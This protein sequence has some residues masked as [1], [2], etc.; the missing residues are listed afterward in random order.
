VHVECARQAGYVLGFDITPVKGSRKDQVPIVNIKGDVG[1]MVAAIW[2]KEHIPQ[3]TVVHHIQDIVDDETGQT[4]LQ[5]YSQKFK[6]ADL[7]LTGTV[8]KATLI[9]QS[10][11][12]VQPAPV[13][14]YGTRRISTIHTNG[15]SHAGRNSLS[16]AKVEEN[17]SEK[18]DNELKRI[19]ATCEVDV[20][21]KWWS[22]PAVEVLPEPAA[23]RVNGTG[24]DAIDHVV[25]AESLGDDSGGHAA[26]AAAALHQDTKPSHQEPIEF[27][28]HKCHFKKVKREPTPVPEP[29][30]PPPAPV[31]VVPREEIRL[32]NHIPPPIGIPPP[33]VEMNQAPRVPPGYAWQVPPS[34]YGNGS[35]NGWSRPSPVSQVSAHISHINGNG[36][37]RL[38]SVVHSPNGHSRPSIQT[39]PHSPLQNG[40]IPHMTNGYPPRS[41]HGGMGMHIPNGN[42]GPYTSPRVETHHLTNGV[43]PPRPNDPPFSN[44]N[45]SHDQMYQRPPYAPAQSSPPLLNNHLQSRANSISHPTSNGH[46]ENGRVNGGA[47]ASPSLRNLLS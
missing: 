47:S 39:V 19:C 3:K 27:Q 34:G 26:L 5:L 13:A 45:G 28:C 17:A 42:Y 40:H 33:D 15:T 36:P 46:Q 38:P 16:H 14:V 43:P 2:C 11:K 41:P 12:A 1:T 18:A 29:P 8:R 30:T 22:F 10:T 32:H 37:P 21:P 7:T 24:H 20:S 6:Q 44:H 9:N 23:I 4:A 31:P 35:Y 25:S